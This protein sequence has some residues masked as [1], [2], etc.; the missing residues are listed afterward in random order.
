[1]LWIQKIS[2]S[3]W[4]LASGV[5]VCTYFL[6]NEA[7]QNCNCTLHKIDILQ[8]SIDTLSIKLD[9]QAIIFHYKTDTIQSKLDGKLD[10]EMILLEPKQT[11]DLIPQIWYKKNNLMSNEV[12]L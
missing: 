6:K 8:N 9:A 2:K 7:V 11:K 10:K 1:M 12:K 3:Y 4:W 5:S